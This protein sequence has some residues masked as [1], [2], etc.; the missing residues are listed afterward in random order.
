MLN[1][2]QTIYGSLMEPMQ[3]SAD[4]RI[5]QQT[6]LSPGWNW[7]SFHVESD[8]LNALQSTFPEANGVM[9]DEVKDHQGGFAAVQSNGQWLTNDGDMLPLTL[10]SRYL[11]HVTGEGYAL[12]LQ[13]RIPDL[14]A[15]T[16]EVMQGWNG[17]GY[18]GF[19]S[20]NLDLALSDLVYQN[21][22]QPGDVLQSQ[23]SGF[24]MLSPAGYWVG[25]LEAMEPGEGYRLFVES[26]DSPVSFEYP[27]AIV[28]SGGFFRGVEEQSHPWSGSIVTETKHVS[29]VLIS[30][31]VPGGIQVG[32]AL[33]A[34][35][36]GK[37]IGAVGATA[38]EG[39]DNRFFLNLHHDAQDLGPVTFVLHRSGRATYAIAE[40]T[41]KVTPNELHGTWADPFVL[42]FGFPDDGFD[43]NPI[44]ATMG[45]FLMP[46]PTTGTARV[47]GFEPLEEISWHILDAKGKVVR[48]REKDVAGD[49]TISIDLSGEL[50]GLYLMRILHKHGSSTL[51]I[52]KSN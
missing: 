36:N 20:A 21:G 15:C 8:S 17:L 49:G 19:R 48:G 51:R 6:A 47:V 1:N 37:C 22:V 24:A 3:F 9:V 52:V 11:V 12:N 46:N 16:E 5:V 39:L 18:P 32:D 7:L 38:V 29:P 2:D 28:S 44:D 26:L 33:A 41:L 25:S 27:N 30:C 45:I 34:F 14:A 42:H 10:T 43:L 4:D 23:T 31:E 35:V 50:N 13:G 40:E